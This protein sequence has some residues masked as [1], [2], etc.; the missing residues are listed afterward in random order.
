MD[1]ILSHAFVGYDRSEE[2][3]RGFRAAGMAVGRDFFGT[4]CDNQTV[5]WELVRAGCGLGFGSL[6][7]GAGDPTLERIAFEVDIPDLEVWLTA[8]EAVRHT[9][10]VDAV[11]GHL[12]MRLRAMCDPDA[13]GA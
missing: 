4:R 11:W 10:R 13:S 5:Y 6:Q 12:A 9:P 1:D 3:I 7:A 8:H 2:I